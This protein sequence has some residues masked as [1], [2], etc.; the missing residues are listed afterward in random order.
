MGVVPVEDMDLGRFVLF[1]GLAPRGSEALS[2]VAAP[3]QASPELK[4]VRTAEGPL[5]TQRGDTVTCH[6]VLG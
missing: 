1:W 2:G 3:P 5:S 4:P 6:D